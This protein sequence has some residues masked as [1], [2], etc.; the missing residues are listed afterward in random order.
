MSPNV[1]SAAIAGVIAG[2]IYTAIALLTGSSAAAA[3]GVGAIFLVGTAA[4][5]FVVTILIGRSK[6]SRT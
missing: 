5:T 2:V 3:F 6:R 1:R 4:I